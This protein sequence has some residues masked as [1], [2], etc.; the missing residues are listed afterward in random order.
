MKLNS[1]ILENYRKFKKTIIEFPDGVIGIIG[2]NG[3]GK[4]T[5]V[6]AIAW[7]LYGNQSSIVRTD[8][9]SIKREGSPP[10]HAC[11]V[12][13]EFEIEGNQFKIIR[14]MK[15]RAYITNAQ[16]FINKKLEATNAL[17]VTEFI[18]KTLGMDYQSFF[19]SIFARQNELDSLSRLEPYKRKKLILRMLNIDSIEKAIEK[20]KEDKRFKKNRIEAIKTILYDEEGQLKTIKFK[21]ENKNLNEKKGK[22]SIEIKKIEEKL[23]SLKKGESS[24]KEKKNIEEKRYNK[25]NDLNS[26]LMLMIERKKNNKNRISEL[27]NELKNLIEKSKWFEEIK[28]KDIDFERKKMEKEEYE[29]QKSKLKEKQRREKET[30]ELKNDLKKRIFQIE[31]K[32][33]QLNKYVDF[34]K[35][36][37]EIWKKEKENE[38]NKIKL[39]SQTQHLITK[40]ENYNSEIKEIINKRK[41][42]KTLGIDSK[43]PT[44]ERMLGEQFE[45]L[46]SKF[47]NELKSKRSKINMLHKDLENKK[48][49]KNIFENRG[50]AILKREK[51]LKKMEKER[52]STEVLLKQLKKEYEVRKSN[53]NEKEKTLKEMAKIIFDEKKYENLKKELK[54][55]SKIHDEIIGLKREILRIDILKK[56]LKKSNEKLQEIDTTLQKIREEIE[57]LGFDEKD[58]KEIIIKYENIKE[59]IAVNN[60]TLIKLKTELKS[61]NNEIKKLKEQIKEMKK[62]GE[63]VKEQTVELQYLE[64]LVEIFGKFKTHLIYKIGPSLSIYG[65]D[66]FSKL[67]DGKYSEMELNENYEIFIR[68]NGKLYP[69]DRFSGGE[70]DLANLCLRLAI[71]KVIAERSGGLDLSF[72]ILDEIFGSQDIYRK[73]NIIKAL[74]ELSKQFRQIFLITHIEDVKEYMGYVLNVVEGEDGVSEVRIVG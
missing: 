1:I 39:T 28:I 19:T 45:T 6:E 36:L 24:L 15:G 60:I 71:S 30:F 35:D 52:S 7:V 40:I 4:S 23:K 9:K 17:Q 70:V 49:E 3:V 44:C 74:N 8:K 67:T 53:L 10:S 51:Y 46:L 29:L 13:L 61:L 56:N 37:K 38:D 62:L 42:L 20:A 72:I 63:S 33:I 68:E 66:L 34:E 47:E 50:L 48:N 43:C 64:K 73:R 65:S 21:I 18:E 31:T 22:N 32:E 27:K 41:K 26:Q 2:L 25:K 11:R 16:A 55:L 54:I 57:T 14:E 5:I 12:I 59:E 58:Y 69:I